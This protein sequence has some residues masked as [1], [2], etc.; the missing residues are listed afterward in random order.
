MKLIQCLLV[1]L[2]GT[3]GAVCAE[4]EVRNSFGH[5]DLGLGPAPVPLPIFGIGHRNQWGKNGFDVTLNA[6]TVVAATA[7]KFTPSYIRYFTPNL[8]A[9]FY[10]GVGVGVTG[11]FGSGGQ[12][13]LSPEVLFGKEHQSDTGGRRF[14]QGQI[15]F[16][17]YSPTAHKVTCFPIVTFTY[18]ICF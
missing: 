7:V 6:T 14:F 15:G 17:T 11:I 9:Q 12:A 4:S 13:V 1:T 16:P 2:I 3:A 8:Q 5:V 18:G 10:M